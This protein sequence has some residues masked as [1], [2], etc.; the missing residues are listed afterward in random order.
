MRQKLDCTCARLCATFLLFF[1][2]SFSASAQKTITGKIV[3]SKDNAPVGFATITVKGTNVATVSDADGSFTINASSENSTLV[4]S[5]V[6]FI[7]KEVDGS[8]GNVTVTLVETTS[9]L[10]E[11]VVTGYTAQK[12]KDITGAVAVVDVSS[13][14]SVPSGNTSSL[15]QG[16]ASGVTVIGS[17]QPGGGV[18]LRVRGITSLGSSNPLIIIDGTPGSFSDLNPDDVA[19]IQVLKDA[20]ATAIYGIQGA[21]GVIVVTTK[22]GRGAAK[23]NYNG[24]VGVQQPLKG[25][26]LANTQE[27]ANVIWQQAIGSGV[28]PEH[29]Q[30]GSGASPVIPDYITPA[31]ASE[32]DPGTAAGDY[33]FNPGQS[34]DNRITKANKTGTDWWNEIFDPAMIQSHTVSGSGSSEKSNYFF[35]L[36]YFNQQGTLTNSY[37]KRYSA[38]INTVFNVKNNIRIGEN[39]Y[40][41]YKQNPGFT[42]QNEG[43]AISMTYREP[44]IIPIYDIMGNYAGTGSDGLSNAANPVAVV[45]RQEDNKSNDWQVNGNVFAEVD[46]LKHFTARTTFGGV[47]DN[48]YYYYFTYTAYENAEGNTSANG[49]TEGSGYGSTWQWTNTLNY[50]QIFG[51]HNIKALIG[52]EAKNVYNRS[53]SASRSK[54]IITSP[55]YWTLNTGD[56]TTQSNSGASPYQLA[57]FSL[58][59]RVDYSFADKY[60]LSGTI[61]RDGASVFAKDN[62]YGNFPSVTAGW[63]I[64]QE[65]FMKNISWL[66]ELKLRGSWGKTGSI[67]NIGATNPYNLYSSGVGY[68]WYPITGSATTPTQGFYASQFGNENTTWEQDIIT[69]IGLDASILKGKLDFSIEWYKK[70]ISG[71]LYP[72]QFQIGNYIGGTSA[73]YVNAGNIQNTGI[74]FSATYRANITKDLHLDLTGTLTS[75]NSKVVSLPQGYSYVDQV[76]GGSSRIGAFVRTQPGQA[77][78]AFYGY[79]VIGFFQN[80]DD[81]AKSP[82]QDDAAPGRFKYR[83]VNGDN[84]ITADDRTFFGNPNPDFT[85]GINLALSYKRWDLS[86]FFYGSKGNDVIN[87]IKYWTDFPQVFGGNVSKDAVYRSVKL[88]NSQTGQPTSVSDPLA[89]VSNSDAKVPVLEQSPSFSTT[90]VFNSYYLENGSYFRCKQIQIGYTIPKETLQRVGIDQFRVYFQVANLFT[91]TKYSGL[92][93]ELQASDL[94]NNSNFGIDFGNYPANQKNFNIGVNLTF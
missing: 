43:N 42:N 66:S 13:F 62:R 91:I 33:V 24:F 53:M 38:R 28:D 5:S 22:K 86:A 79:D 3:N 58:F 31:G 39:A 65:N 15:L 56:P 7:T 61:R 17:G 57:L 77:I 14:K 25:F 36:N 12:K 92:D 18:N 83:D 59:G 54:Y 75:Y 71:L 34:D 81:V 37:L 46:F 52:S 10:D 23:I 32:G 9:S 73:P 29:P 85:Y 11:I 1:F 48:Y 6:G 51:R 50:S 72:L 30:F 27:Y 16:Q 87:Y 8:S 70:K 84:K 2:L 41:F 82:S 78:G 47:F 63:R 20:G 44:P 45:N 19:S 55:D 67:S 93:P 21:N 35:S 76:S 74:D 69:N 88:V 26:D 80:A 89:Q 40:V 68:S 90:T 49:F 64:S 4:V 60:L 94:N